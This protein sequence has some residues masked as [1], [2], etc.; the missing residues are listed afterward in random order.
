[1]K[2]TFLFNDQV[3]GYVSDTSFI[4]DEYDY[5]LLHEQRY[6]AIRRTFK[7]QNLQGLEQSIEC[8]IDLSEAPYI[9]E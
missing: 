2:I 4:P 5:V 7:L 1:M 6:M 9:E 8:D 3:M